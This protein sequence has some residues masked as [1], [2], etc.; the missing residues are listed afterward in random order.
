MKR[1]V[2]FLFLASTIFYSC[3]DV[4]NPQLESAEP[5]L[6]IDAWINNLPDSQK[7]F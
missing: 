7:L 4:I 6:V 1:L 3:E 2:Y 5:V